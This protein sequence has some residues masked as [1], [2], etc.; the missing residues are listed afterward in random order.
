MKQLS[1]I[2]SELI[3]EYI[4]LYYASTS[5]NMIEEAVQRM[6]KTIQEEEVVKK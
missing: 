2:I 1:K 5:I 3:G 6:R 4:R